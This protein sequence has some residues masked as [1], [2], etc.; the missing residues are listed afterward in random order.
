MN[1]AVSVV[2]NCIFDSNDEKALPLNIGSLNLMCDCSDEDDYFSK[3]QFMYY[4]LRYV[5]PKSISK[6][7]QNLFNILMYNL[8]LYTT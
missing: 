3:F 4:S 7:V 8:Y 1:H 2:G 6:H 5:N